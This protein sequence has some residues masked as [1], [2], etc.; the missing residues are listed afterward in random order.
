MRIMVLVGGYDKKHN[1]FAV[2]L[3]CAGKAQRNSANRR[4]S[5]VVA[6]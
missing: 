5:P 3:W 2:D 1:G 6:L 4:C